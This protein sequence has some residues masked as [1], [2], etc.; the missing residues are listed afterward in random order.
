MDSDNKSAFD[1]LV[2]GL[3]SADRTAM[4]NRINQGSMQRV[5]LVSDELEPEKK[6]ETLS[7]RLQNESFLYRLYLWIRSLFTRNSVEVVFNEELLSNLAKKVNHA[8]PGT[9][10]HKIHALDYIFYERLQALKEACDFFRPYFSVINEDQGDFYVFLSSFVAPELSEKI[11]KEADPFIYP[12]TKQGGPEVRN[13][14]LR[15]LD[16]IL[17]DM[18]EATRLKI[19]AAI[20]TINW[21]NKTVSLPYLHFLAQF[22]NVTG[23]VYTANYNHCKDDFNEMVSVFAKARPVDNEILEAIYL[24]SQRKNLSE[25]VQEKDIE[26]AVREFMN[27]AGSF[28][29]TIQD[30]PGSVSIKRLGRIVNNSY[31]W[32]PKNM[33]GAEGWFASFRSQW[34][35][36]FD[37]RWTEWLREQK[38]THLS[39]NLKLDFGLSDFPVMKYRPWQKLWNSVSFACELTGG[40][41]SWFVSEKYEEIVLPL[42]E[43][44]MEGI[45]IKSENRT[46]YSEALNDFLNAN[47]NMQILLEKLS[48]K[49]DL[50]K[51]FEDYAT[52]QVHTL[53]VQNQ[54]N[55]VMR[56][57]EGQVKE[58]IKQFCKGARIMERVFHGFFD[59]TK[60]G[61]HEGL[62]N[63]NTIKGRD[64]HAFRDKLMDIRDLLRKCLFYISELEPIDSVT[65]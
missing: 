5:P 9:V 41:L 28:L 1:K 59:E 6:F 30:F 22:T 40:F 21:L 16:G 15:K 14:L 10:N 36:I 17:K 52:N 2:A 8:H 45:F 57:T 55:N 54:I 42:N 51:M 38:K 39:E 24:F 11:N 31:D 50:G 35:K 43:V 53:Q 63:I 23:N 60:D 25:N 48:P 32:E 27:K 3:N 58:Y 13:E 18:E 56:E 47:T 19:Y 44:V 29:G 46:E 37:I 64:S 34:H 4:L 61:I 12:F 26:K 62:Q 65:E 7:L 49:G 20:S 33:E